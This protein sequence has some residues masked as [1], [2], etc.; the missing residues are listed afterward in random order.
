METLIG[1]ILLVAGVAVFCLMVR[2]TNA[3]GRELAQQKPAPFSESYKPELLS[4]QQRKALGFKNSSS[5]LGSAPASVQIDAM[6]AKKSTRAIRTGWSIGQ[7]AFT[8]E[9]SSGEI[10][11][12]TVSVHSV[13]R[14][15]IKGECHDRKAERTFRVDRILGDLIDCETGEVLSP[16]KWA[17]EKAL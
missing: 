4:K 8:Y 1:I 7:V 12:R 3:R 6:P 13:T 14:S 10:T 2:R 5:K 17:R 16:E 15:H 11:D 9:D